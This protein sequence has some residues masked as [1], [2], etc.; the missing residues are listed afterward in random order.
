LQHDHGV[1]S[2]AFSSDGARIMTASLYATR[3]WDAAS[4]AE[5]ARL[6]HDDDV[7]N[8]VFSPDGA[9]VVTASNDKIARVWDVTWAAKLTGD[10][11]IRAV[12]RT[13]LMGQGLLTEAELGILRPI[14]GEVN[15]DVV[16]RWLPPSPEDITIENV[17]GQWQCHRAMALALARKDWADR[18]AEIDATLAKSR[19]KRASSSPSAV[20]DTDAIVAH[21][22]MPQG[23]A[24]RGRPSW[25][26]ALALLVLASVI[27][28]LAVSGKIDFVELLRQLSQ[29][30]PG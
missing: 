23:A 21:A 19:A 4:G 15:P 29:M 20:V 10:A 25:K 17:L 8:A 30:L 28:G 26:I 13:R 14:L 9:R 22:A 7:A 27:A 12:A 1:N 11:L 16:S 2:A 3:V 5:I 6:V 18:G 24:I